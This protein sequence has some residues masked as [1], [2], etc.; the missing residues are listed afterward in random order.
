MGNEFNVELARRFGD[1]EDKTSGFRIYTNFGAFLP[2]EY[3][4]IKVNRVAGQRLTALGG[5]AM[6]WAFR[7]GTMVSF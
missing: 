2:G 3:Y 5:D 1:P 6:F 4:A 7:F